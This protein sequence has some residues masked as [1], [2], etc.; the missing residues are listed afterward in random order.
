MTCFTSPI[1]P[2]RVVIATVAFGMG[3]NCHNVRTVVHYGPPEDIDTYIQET[4]R[5]GRDGQSSHALLLARKRS[6]HIE[7]DMAAYVNCQLHV[8]GVNF[9]LGIM[10]AMLMMPFPSVYVVIFVELAVNVASVHC[11]NNVLYSGG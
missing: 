10:R 4:G 5:V 1:S 3:I 8:V 11:T 9:C 7:E 2:L 6:A